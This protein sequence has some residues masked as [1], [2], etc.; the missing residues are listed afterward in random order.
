MQY[1]PFC[2]F[3]I[4]Q[5]AE[6][7]TTIANGKYSL[8]LITVMAG[9]YLLAQTM[10]G[11]D[12]PVNILLWLILGIATAGIVRLKPAPLSTRI[13]DVEEWFAQYNI[14]SGWDELKRQIG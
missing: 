2:I 8:L 4:S 5:I 9:V 3:E 1:N 13:V 12:E 11:Q 7:E 14:D 10:T 6:K